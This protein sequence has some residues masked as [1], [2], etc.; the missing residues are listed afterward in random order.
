MSDNFSKYSLDLEKAQIDYDRQVISKDSQLLSIEKNINDIKRNLDDSSRIYN[1]ALIN[2]EE[3]KKIALINFK[4]SDTTDTNSKAYLEL[5]KSKLS[6]E[7]LL[8]TNKQTFSSY[9]RDVQKE[10]NEL[11][12]NLSNIIEF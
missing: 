5:E 7:N 2:A 1:N 6:Y 12:V 11:Y 4:N 3:K 10:Y 8:N 9:I